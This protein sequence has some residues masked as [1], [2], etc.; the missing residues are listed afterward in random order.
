M[1]CNVVNSRVISS[2][3]LLSKDY[4]F[5]LGCVAFHI[6]SYH[7]SAYE[8]TCCPITKTIYLNFHINNKIMAA[9]S[10]ADIENLIK[11]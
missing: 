7:D 1:L 2:I 6:I 10:Q 8:G 5:T 4:L 11:L 3:V 9:D